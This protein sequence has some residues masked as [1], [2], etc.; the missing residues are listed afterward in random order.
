MGFDCCMSTETTSGEATATE[1]E[2]RF[3]AIIAD[4]SLN[5]AET[6]F[7]EGRLAG[8]LLEEYGLAGTLHRL[9]TEKDDTFRFATAEGDFT[10]KVSSSFERPDLIDLQTQ[11]MAHVAL[12]GRV[13][14]PQLRA[15]LDGRFT[16]DVGAGLGAYP[17]ILRVMSYLP[18]APQGDAHPSDVQLAQ[19]GR[20][21]AR[22][23]CTLADM[24][25]PAEDRLL[26]WDLRQLGGLR[27][28]LDVCGESTR[29]LARQ[30]FDEFDAVV[31]PIARSLPKQLLHNDANNFNLL[32][33]EDDPQYV[34]GVIDFGDCVRTWVA[35]DVSVAFGSQLSRLDDPWNR[36]LALLGG[37][38]GERTLSNDE[39]R[40]VAVLGPARPALRI[41]AQAWSTRENP[42]RAAYLATHTAGLMESLE[43]VYAVPLTQRI[44]DVLDLGNAAR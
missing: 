24:R 23:S 29:E 20:M 15:A 35:A 8:I 10:V 11:V 7:D 6:C 28:L 26:F 12:D 34:T 32:V 44:D 16:L 30:A 4:S 9:P 27:P 39:L 22:L 25:H 3:R 14:V 42:E 40:A 33:D 41:L 31:A 43:A 5:A 17:R 2:H 13:P 37:Y 19:I 21:V 38:L 18:G 36:G 1:A